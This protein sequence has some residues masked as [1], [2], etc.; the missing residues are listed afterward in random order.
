MLSLRDPPPI[1]SEPEPP[2]KI[3]EDKSTE[4]VQSHS[5]SVINSLNRKSRRKLAKEILQQTCHNIVSAPGKLIC[6]QRKQARP[7]GCTFLGSKATATQVSLVRE[8]NKPVEMVIDSG[9]D[10]TLISA[11]YIKTL[12]SPP[13]IK[14]GQ[15][16][17][18]IQLTGSATISGYVDI[19]IFFHTT[20]GP[21]SMNIEAY[22]VKNMTTPV[23]LGNDFADQYDLSI[24][25]HE[26]ETRLL[27]GSSQR[28][29]PVE[30][31]TRP[32]QVDSNGKPFKVHLL[33]EVA[34]KCLK[35][36]AHRKKKQ[37]RQRKLR[38]NSDRYIRTS[39]STT[40]PPE[41]VKRIPVSTTNLQDADYHYAERLL[42]FHHDV[43]DC[44]GP[45]DSIIE[46]VN[47]YLQVANFSKRTL[48]IPL[49]QA[50]AIKQS[51]SKWLKS[52]QSVNP[53]LYEEMQKRALLIKSLA[54][55]L[56]DTGKSEE[57]PHIPGDEP[58]E[59][60]LKSSEHEPTPPKNTSLSEIDISPHLSDDQAK[61]L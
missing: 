8:D 53:Q 2:D 39:I 47:P 14:T 58:L 23:I 25:R 5:Y 52:R 29:V 50:I 38:Q 35:T 59:G 22:V 33:D 9:S 6:L 36:A 56:G 4:S 37:L 24:L 12:K 21:V 13:K 26:G 3:T 28:Y 18:L 11:E 41:T 30:N 32:H 40:I 48:R 57:N 44:Y 49:G 46:T 31:S 27:L 42:N 61:D 16:I 19:P 51:P 43:E 15:R 54:K 34:S 1:A 7:P 60:G 45:P 17:S 10:I 55:N 20:Q